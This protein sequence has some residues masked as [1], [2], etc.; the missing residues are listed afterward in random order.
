MYND[1]GCGELIQCAEYRG[2]WKT[3]FMGIVSVRISVRNRIRLSV[4]LVSGYAHVFLLLSVV[5]GD[6]LFSDGH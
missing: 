4:R 5:T 3:I 1:A 6:I 2:I